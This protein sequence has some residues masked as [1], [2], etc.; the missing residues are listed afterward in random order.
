M[1]LLGTDSAEDPNAVKR[2]RRRRRRKRKTG[3]TDYFR[4]WNQY[5]LMVKYR[6]NRSCIPCGVCRRLFCC[7]WCFLAAKM[8]HA[9]ADEIE[10]DG[11]RWITKEKKKKLNKKCTKIT[12]NNDCNVKLTVWPIIAAAYIKWMFFIYRMIKWLKSR[13]TKL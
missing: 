10:F 6:P 1:A 3:E 7:L 2:T 8:A 12:C 4:P 5:R 9:L 13:E 11:K